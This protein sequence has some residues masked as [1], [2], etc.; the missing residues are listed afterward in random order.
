M[1]HANAI[2]VTMAVALLSPSAF[3]Q[4]GGPS[5]QPS[6]PEMKGRIAT[7]AWARAADAESEEASFSQMARTLSLGCAL[8]L[9]L[10][11]AA[12]QASFADGAAPAK[13]LE[14]PKLV[15]QGPPLGEP[16]KSWVSTDKE[17][18]MTRDDRN[19]IKYMESVQKKISRKGYW[20]YMKEVGR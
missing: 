18:Q 13:K 9:L 8:G 12:P 6:H 20:N 17:S 2:L 11:V 3:V 19:H 10:A 7:E 1:A 4:L 14:A 16:Y 15:Y 5:R